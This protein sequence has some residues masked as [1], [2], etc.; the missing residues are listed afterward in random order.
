MGKDS[1]VVC[2]AAPVGS[3]SAKPP[4]DARARPERAA[5]VVV[6]ENFMELSGGVGSGNKTLQAQISR[7]ELT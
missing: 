2:S 6:M 1:P 7:S 4:A 3:Q 5:K